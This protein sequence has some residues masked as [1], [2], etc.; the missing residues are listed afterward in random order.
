[1]ITAHL[2]VNIESRSEGN[3]IEDIASCLETLAGEL[4]ESAA[5]I[6][7]R[8][9]DTITC[10]TTEINYTVVLFKLPPKNPIN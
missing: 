9:S 7:D 3:R 10:G 4:R 2:S 6:T 1:M 8:V 5:S